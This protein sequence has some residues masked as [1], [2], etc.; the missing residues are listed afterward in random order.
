MLTEAL[1]LRGR[2]LPD[3]TGRTTGTETETVELG[4]AELGTAGLELRI[5]AVKAPPTTTTTAAALPLPLIIGAAGAELP[6][7]GALGV[8]PALAGPGMPPVSIGAAATRVPLPTGGTGGTIVTAAMT[9]TERGTGTETGTGSGVGTGGEARRRMAHAARRQRCPR[10]V[11]C[12]R[13]RCRGVAARMHGQRAC[14]RRHTLAAPREG[15]SR[16]AWAVWGISAR[17]RRKGR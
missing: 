16:T 17:A 4:T 15:A 12:R 1:L 7:L 9:G 6:L 8:M 13:R 2:E 5:G 3:T 14:R 11:C 10:P